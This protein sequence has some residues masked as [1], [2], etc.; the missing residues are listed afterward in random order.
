VH[1]SG[2]DGIHLAGEREPGRFLYC[3]AG[4]ATG[5]AILAGY[6]S[7][8]SVQRLSEGFRDDFRPDPPRVTDGD[9]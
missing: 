3:L 1:G 9:G 5:I 7:N 4:G 6:Q 8:V 2:D